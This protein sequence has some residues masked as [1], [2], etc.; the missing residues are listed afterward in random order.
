MEPVEFRA[1]LLYYYIGRKAIRNPAYLLRSRG[2][3]MDGSVWVIPHDVMPW[4][5]IARMKDTPRV[6]VDHFEFNK[7]EAGRLADTAKRHLRNKSAAAVSKIA[8]SQDT[9]YDPEKHGTPEEFGEW[10][11][12][13]IRADCK[14]AER[15]LKDY[16]SAGRNFG[17]SDEDLNLS[18]A[19]GQIR[20]ISTINRNRAAIYTA[21]AEKLRKV[22]ELAL[23]SAADKDKL[24]A[25]IMADALRDH[26]LEDE[27]DELMETFLTR[28]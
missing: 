16:Q 18:S 3:W 27:A 26:G 7:A 20:V 19:I 22:G 8:K 12:R 11:E 28:P 1:H 2:I 24:P 17:L 21:G 4:L 15:L 9:V 23:A 6:T 14:Q 10:L 5:L 25:G 13:K